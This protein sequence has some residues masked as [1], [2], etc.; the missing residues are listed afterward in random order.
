MCFVFGVLN[1][2][3]EIKNI[4]PQIPTSKYETP[5]TTTTM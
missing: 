5:N 2:K 4:I 1:L 3:E